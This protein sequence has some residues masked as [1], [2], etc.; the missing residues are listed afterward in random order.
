[1]TTV[2]VG[3]GP[4][5]MI[6]AIL[7]ARSGAQVTLI[8]ENALIGGH[9]RYHAY[10]PSSLK[11]GDDS[12]RQHLVQYV[13]S[14]GVDVRSSTIVWAAYRTSSGYEIQCSDS[15]GPTSFQATQMIVAVGTTDREFPVPGASL[16]G[17][18]TERALRILITQYGVIP[19]ARCLI[20]GNDSDRMANLERLLSAE[21]VSTNSIAP[22]QVKAIDGVN[23]VE[24]VRLID[25]TEIP[26][27]IVI[28]ALGERPDTQL[29]GM[30]GIA[31]SWND[32]ADSWA[33]DKSECGDGI[34]V[35]G[36]AR[37]GAASPAVLIT[38]AI[39]AVKRITGTNPPHIP[40]VTTLLSIAGSG[41]RQ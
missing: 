13:A 41:E 28:L 9:L 11:Q 39:E 19:G 30:L 1:M 10:N 35:V 15:S 16:P 27:D 17:V 8:D 33:V 14:E 23:G 36:G 22:S 38:D 34:F 12:W 5:G 26:T 18:L 32:I 31:R 4:T 6:S 29:V 24:S 7:L 21:L 40:R 25:G 3:A 2:V 20:V 37:V